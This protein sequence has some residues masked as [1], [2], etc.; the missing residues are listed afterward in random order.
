[1]SW[2]FE[3]KGVV[4]TAAADEDDVFLVAA[5][6]GAEDVRGS[7]G[8]TEVVTRP[9]ALRTVEAA[10][11][12]AGIQ[13]ESAESTMM[14]KSSVS[15]EGAEAK[16]VLTLIDNLEELDDVQDVYANFD[17]SDDVLALVAE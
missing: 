6:A 12:T 1:V 17:I 4:V 11:R 9:D 7:D 15:V 3:P 10:L 14:P 13:V 16:R 2:I 8:T 5:D